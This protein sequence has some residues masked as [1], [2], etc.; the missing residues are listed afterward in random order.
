M[1]GF[2][3]G[4]AVELDEEELN[5]AVRRAQHLLAAGGDPHRP[6]ELHG[7]A[8]TA[9][10]ADLD[11]PERRSALHAGLEALRRD[12]VGQPVMSEPLAKLLGD[13]ALAWQAYALA[14]LADTLGPD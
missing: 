8:V 11:T 14:L 3:A 10:A 7:R 2:L 6:L 1:L 9:L 13:G 5:G 4:R 12:L